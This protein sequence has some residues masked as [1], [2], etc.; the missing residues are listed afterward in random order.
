MHHRKIVRRSNNETLV[1][2]LKK[3]Q[4]NCYACRKIKKSQK[5]VRKKDNEMS[6][7]NSARGTP[8]SSKRK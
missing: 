5:R 8:I 7:G 2:E 6:S 1:K 3:T 4:Y